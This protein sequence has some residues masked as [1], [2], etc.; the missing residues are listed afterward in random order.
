MPRYAGPTDIENY[1]VALVQHPSR[2]RNSPWPFRWTIIRLR[3]LA[4]H[5]AAKRSRR[6]SQGRRDGRAGWHGKRSSRFRAAASAN[7]PVPSV[8]LG[9]MPASLI[10]HLAKALKSKVSATE[11]NPIPA[12]SR[13]GNIVMTGGHLRLRSEDRLDTGRPR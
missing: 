13:V 8:A 11:I 3:P 10:C 1:L 5:R 4:L 7:S 9:E 6:C 12:A 2:P